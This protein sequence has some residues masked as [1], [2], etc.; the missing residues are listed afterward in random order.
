MA[1]QSSWLGNLMET[2][3]PGRLQ[4]MGSQKSRTWLSN[5]NNK[6][7]VN[8]Y[9]LSLTFKTNPAECFPV[10]YL[11]KLVSK[12]VSKLLTGHEQKPTWSHS[13]TK[14]FLPQN[15]GLMVETKL[16]SKSLNSV[17][18]TVLLRYTYLRYV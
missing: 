12:E 16:G 4:S 1:T 15:V 14:Y 18:H 8:L 11:G 2:E 6:F 3:E 13:K 17:F 5:L 9:S 10:I 7:C